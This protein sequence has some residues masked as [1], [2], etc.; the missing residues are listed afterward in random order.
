MHFDHQERIL[1][2]LYNILGGLFLSLFLHA[3]DGVISI[4][5]D[6][7]PITSQGIF[8]DST[9]LVLSGNDSS[10]VGQAVITGDTVDHRFDSLAAGDYSLAV[11]IFQHDYIIAENF[12]R[13]YLAPDET[14]E[15]RA[16]FYWPVHIPSCI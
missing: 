9:K 8:V 5:L 6:L 14:R 4:N 3:G 16:G 10:I 12:S 11:E 13:G 15:I 2:R 7:T 1:K